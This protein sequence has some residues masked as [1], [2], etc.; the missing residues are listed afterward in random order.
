MKV[1]MYLWIIVDNRRGLRAIL[2]I[3][4]VQVLSSA[5]P[6]EATRQ[7]Y[8]KGIETVDGFLGLAPCRSYRESC[9]VLCVRLWQAGLPNRAM[10]TTATA[11]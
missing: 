9:A 1:P 8:A 3:L 4:R 5:A 10:P 6:I 7:I 11:T 2:C